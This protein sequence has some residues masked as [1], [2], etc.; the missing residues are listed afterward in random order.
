MT[1]PHRPRRSRLGAGAVAGLAA[2]TGVLLTATPASAAPV[3]P[4]APAAAAAGCG[5]LDATQ[6]AQLLDC[7]S[8]D[9]VK[10]HLDALQGI[11]DDNGG[12]RA[13]GT[14]GYDASADYVAEKAAAAGLTVTT[15]DFE[16][17]FFEQNSAAF[18]QTAPTPADYAD[19][20]DFAVMALSG[21]GEVSG[22]AVPVDV[23][24]PSAGGSTS[25][26]EAADFAAFPAGSI[27]LLQRGTCD[28]GIKATNAEAAGAAAAVIMNEGN[29]PDRQELLLGNLGVPVGIPVIGVPFALGEALQNA[30]VSI[31][32]DA[33]S[34][35]R[36]TSNVF[37]ELPGAS[38]DQVLVVGSH[39]DSV[40]EGPGINDNGSGTASILAVAEQLAGTTPPVTVRFAWWGAEEL[41]LVGST[42]YVASLPPA[43]LEKIYAYLN[44]DMVA[45]PN[46][47]NFL[48]DG[49]DSD[50]AGAGPGPAGSAQIEDVFEKFFADR[51][52]PFEGTD[53]NGRSDYGPFI[54]AGIPAGGTFTG[55]EG[56]KTEEQAA[57]Y[58]GTAGQ[59]YDS[60]YHEACDTTGNINDEALDLHSDAIATATFTLA[61]QPELVAGAPAP[62]GGGAG[63]GADD[64]GLDHEHGGLTG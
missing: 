12:T 11:A 52:Q 60:C 17:P 7:V 57:T 14:A 53:F 31:Q 44:F 2:M 4:V 63:G 18:S 33:V 6:G 49:D 20:T 13:S 41:G 50:A 32:V 23:L 61:F 48:Y 51:G 24:L 55:A 26:C 25:G 36:Q 15:Q 9:A 28:F 1:A 64:G 22:T 27:A 45:S 40:P 34:E 37:A 39:L 3:A 43:E 10:G 58:G 5:A 8:L 29:A 42:E 30:T 38:A 62:A 54:A 19:G 47:V 59:P 21:S 56:V 16:F 35:I 46:Y